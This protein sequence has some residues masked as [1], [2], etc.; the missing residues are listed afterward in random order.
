M[1]RGVIS[2]SWA[3]GRAVEVWDVASS[4]RRGVRKRYGRARARD[5]ST[6][7]SA[8]TVTAGSF[9]A[10][11]R[12]EPVEFVV[13]AVVAVVEEH[14]RPGAGT[15]GELDR[16][17]GDRVAEARLRGELLREQQRVVDQNVGALRK[18]DGGRV[19]LPKPSSPGPSAVGQ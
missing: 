17:V 3:A 4:G 12:R 9:R 1:G 11:R 15:S 14:H 8:A 5:S 10:K 2:V 7:P 16:V 19:V 18:L 13:G 6:E